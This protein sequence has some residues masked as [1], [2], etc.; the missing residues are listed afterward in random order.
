M[1]WNPEWL[2]CISGIGGEGKQ[3][4]WKFSDAVKQGHMKETGKP[5][6]GLQRKMSVVLDA[7][8]YST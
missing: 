6:V 8:K 1:A 3:G 5:R 4:R 2:L 7:R